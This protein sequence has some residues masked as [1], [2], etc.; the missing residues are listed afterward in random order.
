MTSYFYLYFVLAAVVSR[1]WAS[2][3]GEIGEDNAIRNPTEP[4]S[5]PVVT[6]TLSPIAV[7]PSAPVV[8]SAPAAVVPH[9]S[10]YPHV[11]PY[12]AIS[13]RSHYFY[14]HTEIHNVVRAFSKESGHTS[15]TLHIYPSGHI[16]EMTR[17]FPAG[18]FTDML[19]WPVR[20]RVHRRKL[21]SMKRT[22]KHKL[23]H[24]RNRKN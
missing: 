10:I 13:H 6:Q 4:I 1:S 8:A 3:Q 18:R 23:I 22:H 21:A 7:S 14:P 15:D 19:P 24:K 20:S 16:P 2:L 5:S 11:L 12:A 17:L 9:V